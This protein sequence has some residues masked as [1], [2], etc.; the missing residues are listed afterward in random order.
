MAIG[1]IKTGKKKGK[2]TLYVMAR[3]KKKKWTDMAKE[4]Y[5]DGSSR[6]STSVPKCKATK[7]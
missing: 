2:T 6:S 3:C 7:K 4:T 1:K 5:A